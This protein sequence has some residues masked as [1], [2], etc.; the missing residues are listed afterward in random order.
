MILGI[1]VDTCDI[2]RIRRAI[3]SGTEAGSPLE[4][5]SGT[6]G[7]N[8]HGT[9]FLRHVFTERERAA[10]PEG[11]T[12]AEYFAARFAAKEAVFKAV[13]PLLPEKHFDLR[14]VETLHYDDGCPYVAADGPLASVLSEAGVK[15]LHLSVTTE[16]HYA[17][18]FVIAEG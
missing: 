2:D 11:R 13:A 1:G 17:T 3:R 10:A 15:R 4:G 7:V 12:R 16:G 14:I 5:T 9:P 18:A 8:G 6:R